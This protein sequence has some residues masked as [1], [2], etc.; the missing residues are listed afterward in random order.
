[1]LHHAPETPLAVVRLERV[2]QVPGD[3][4]RYADRAE[5]RREVRRAADRV[6]PPEVDR[7]GIR[8]A[9]E[10]RP[11]D[12]GLRLVLRDPERHRVDGVPGR[13]E[14]VGDEGVVEM[15]ERV[16]DVEDHG[17]ET[18]HATPRTTARRS[19]KALAR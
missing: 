8:S 3:G 19:A 6:V 12:R 2:E 4:G 18:V 7:R 17:A 11:V 16:A 10:Q 9:G 5:D 15:E 13:R 1:G 14:R